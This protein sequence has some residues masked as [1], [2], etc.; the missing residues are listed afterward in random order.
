M[1]EKQDVEAF[2]ESIKNLQK[3]I[4][5]NLQKEPKWARNDLENISNKL[6]QLLITMNNQF[7]SDDINSI[8]TF[9]SACRLVGREKFKCNYKN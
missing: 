8:K 6:T 9:S 3:E 4:E 5:K 1:A 2:Y 7:P